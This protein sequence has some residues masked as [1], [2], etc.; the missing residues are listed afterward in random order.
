MMDGIFLQTIEGLGDPPLVTSS[1]EV[2]EW[3]ESEREAVVHEIQAD[4]PLCQPPAQ[5]PQEIE[6]SDETDREIDW[7]H[8]GQREARLREI[9][10]AE[11]RLMDGAYGRCKDC[12][13]SIDTRRLAADPAVA[14]CLT[15]QQSAEA[16]VFSCTL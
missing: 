12:G 14:L 15:C 16:E 4:G 11:D 1:C 6:V 7:H 5:G 2:W 3:L 9:T 13:T 8:R 10:E